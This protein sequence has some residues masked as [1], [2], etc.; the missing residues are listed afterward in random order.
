MDTE[1]K[2]VD[3]VVTQED[4][5]AGKFEGS[6]VGDTVQV[7]EEAPAPEQ[8]PEKTPADTADASD[9]APAE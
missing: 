2:L 3:H 8:S 9:S 6:N 1:K 7:E 5:D 4:L